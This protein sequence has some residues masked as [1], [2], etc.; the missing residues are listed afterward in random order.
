M[1]VISE[2]FEELF[3][4]ENWRYQKRSDRSYTFGFRGDNNRYD[5]WAFIND[6]GNILSI[7]AIIPMTVPEQKRSDLADFLHRANYDMMIGNFEFDV[8][9]GE[10]RFKVSS[11]FFGAKPEPDMISC[12][13]DC[14]LAM[15]DRYAPGVGVILFGD[16]SP[17]Q[18]FL[19][20][21]GGSREERSSIVQ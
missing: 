17:E 19:L 15:A 21:E 11:D 14:A 13:I 6:K 9:D 5:L 7:Y 3:A 16:Q 1:S 8:R 20:V 10:I 2:A 18:A 4:R 12:M